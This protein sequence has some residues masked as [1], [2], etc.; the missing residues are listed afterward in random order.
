MKTTAS[1]CRLHEE[2][3][4]AARL[5]PDVVTSKSWDR[6]QIVHSK[7]AWY[8]KPFQQLRTHLR[9]SMIEQHWRL[10]SSPALPKSTQML[11]QGDPAVQCA[12]CSPILSHSIR[13]ILQSRYLPVTANL[14]EE[15][16]IPPG[17]LKP[18]DHHRNAWH[19]VPVHE[20]PVGKACRVASLHRPHGKPL[21]TWEAP[22]V[23][24][25]QLG[26]GGCERQVPR[27]RREEEVEQRRAWASPPGHLPVPQ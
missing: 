27:D 20:L 17:E 21:P 16:Q 18:S 7:I 2:G 8:H 4:E 23:L 1:P 19:H 9:Q 10:R 22:E 3:W 15:F 5:R 25:R 12:E 6:P 26:G 13:V 24:L 14:L 11:S